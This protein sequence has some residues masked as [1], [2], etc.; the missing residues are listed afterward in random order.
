VLEPFALLGFGNNAPGQ[1]DLDLPAA[2]TV[3]RNAFY[4]CQLTVLDSATDCQNS[5]ADLG[6]SPGSLD[7]V[8][9]EIPKRSAQMATLTP[10]F[11]NSA[12][13]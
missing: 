7:L 1:I 9:D 8:G 13:L 10:A 3:F 5:L 6:R 12:P 2:D 4:Q 11:A